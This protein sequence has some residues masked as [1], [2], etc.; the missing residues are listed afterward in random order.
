MTRTLRALRSLAEGDRVCF[1]VSRERWVRRAGEK[2]SERAEASEEG[3]TDD[4]GEG[5][6]GL[7]SDAREQR[8]SATDFVLAECS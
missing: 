2:G 8:R 3:T 5:A 7:A 6:S 4:G 1:W